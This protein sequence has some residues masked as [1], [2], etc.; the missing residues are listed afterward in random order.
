[1][2][3]MKIAAF[4]VLALL[5]AAPAAAQ[6][7]PDP[8][9]ETDYKHA[10]ALADTL[11]PSA[12]VCGE[13]HPR[14]YEQWSISSHA[15]ANLSPMFNK[16]EQ[17]IND[18]AQGT[19]NHF[20]V[21]CHASVGTALGEP[22]N[23]A[24]WDRAPA[25][26]EGITCVTCHRVGNA[27]GKVNAARRIT[28]GG[29]H[30]PVFGPFETSGGL[31][32]ISD[33]RGY[34]LLVSPD[35]P[36]RDGWIR[37]H[38]TAIQSDFLQ[39]SEFCVA[40]HQVQVHPGIKLETVWEEYRNSPAAK[41]GITCQQCHMGVTPGKNSPY[42]TGPAA[43]I[44]GKYVN[45]NRPATDHTFVGPGYPI[46]HPGLFPFRRED[47]P[48]TPQQWLKFDY[49]R[50]WGH[51]DFENDIPAGY[52]FPPEWQNAADRRTAWKIVE[53]NLVRWRERRTMRRKLLD[54]ASRLDGPF[55]NAPPQSGKPF[56]FEYR[57]KNLNE[58]HNLPSG[59]L[60]AQPELWLNVALIGPDGKIVWESGYVDDEGDVADLQSAGVRSGK[61]EH[62]DQLVSMQAKF[63]TTNVKGT[64]REMY[65]PINL[66][67]DQLPFIRPGGTPN[68]L[69]NHPPFARMEKRSIPP[70]GTRIASYKVPAGAMTQSGTYKLAAR[71][72][73]RT[74]PIYF[75]NFVFA[76]NDMIRS[77]NE[78]A[79]D[80]HA[81]AVLL[82][83]A[84]AAAAAAH[85]E[86][87]PEMSAEATYI[88]PIEDPKGWFGPDPTKYAEKEYSAEEQLAIYEDRKW[89]KNAEPPVQQGIRL[90]DRGAYTPRPTFFGETN[91]VNFHFMTYGDLRFAA[92]QYDNGIP[93]ANGETDQ[94]TLAVRL[95]LDLD[96]A[97]TATERLHAFVRPLDK[98]GSFT[99]YQISGGVENEF[100][101]ELD[102]DVETLFFEGDLNTIRQGFTGNLSKFDLP[103]ALGK[104]PLLMQNGVWFDDAFNGLAFGLTAHN[105]PKYDISNMDVTF[106]AGIDRVTTA[107][108]PGD[109]S[110]V[111]GAAGFADAFEG[112]VEVGYGY[113]EAENDDLSYHNV[114]A[115]FTKRYFGRVA[116]SVRLI[117]NLGQNGVGG[118]KTADGVLILLENSFFKSNPVTLVPYVNL[119]AGFNSPQSLARNADAGGVLR[120]TGINF[121]SDGITRYPTLDATAHDAYG[122]AFGVE[123]LFNNLDGQI[124]IEGAIVQRMGD[125]TLDSEYAL[126]ARYQRRINNA[127]IVRADA[128]KGWRQG[129]E[130]VY[131]VRLE[132]RRKF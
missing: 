25:S 81:Y 80:T 43:D 10:A 76:T 124:V 55:F 103:I 97:I 113:L 68:S 52:T 98:N 19:I 33:A 5:V 38:Q 46:S 123:R 118:T 89:N 54:Q 57:I 83:P 15:Y 79:D 17:R 45:L 70:G 85:D 60:G 12:R 1:M 3:M 2:L 18:L 109:D 82:S 37:I 58:G 14:Q 73:G 69:L 132:L 23:I 110:K 90:Y 117:G 21:R 77:E 63:I 130:D 32:A 75:M 119:F 72:R 11:Y 91:P 26:R 42:A 50:K 71:L 115:A 128:M 65:L 39:K 116:N 106:F 27:Y 22:R 125:G 59:S 122:G 105:S 35:Q 87:H 126:G 64:D 34:Q 96:L 108:A 131:G 41:K 100:I 114:T 20:C 112:Y 74:E 99:R 78:W 51:D 36:D 6:I 4:L 111:F 29:I 48:F 56:A 7:L 49:R 92:A 16:F 121:E 8:L 40:C 107:A 53:E 120:N 9:P 88:G 67:F 31:K 95:N 129:R 101:D 84:S 94:S 61:V 44:K 47:T 102:F 93:A 62:D 104:V 13:C 28:P 127:W 30:E 66:D 86:H 24:W